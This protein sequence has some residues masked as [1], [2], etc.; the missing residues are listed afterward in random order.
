MKRFVYMTLLVAVLCGAAHGARIKAMILDGQNN[1]DW[2]ATTPVLKELLAETGLFT[3]DVVTS[4]PEG[5]D[6][7]NFNPAFNNYGVVILNYAGDMWN[8]AT[9]KAFIDYVRGGGGV[10]VVHAADNAFGQ[11]KEYNEIIGFG[12]WGGRTKDSGPY[13]YLKDGKLF[14]DYENDGPAGAHEGYAK[15]VIDTQLPEHPIMKGMPAKWYQWDELYNFM[16][17]PGKNMTVLATAYSG[18]PKDQGGSGRH[19]PM[20]VTISYGKGRVFHTA[21]GHDE[22]SIRCKGFDATFTRGA[23]WAA[24]GKVT[25]PLP[26]DIPRPLAPHEALGVLDEDDSYHP[27][28]EILAE[29]SDLSDNPGKL[30][31][32]EAQLIGY[33]EDPDTPFLAI[34]GVCNALG[35]TGSKA[36]VPALAN[37]LTEDAEHASAARLALERIEGPEAVAALLDEL[38]KG[39]DFNQVGIINTLGRRREAG[40]VSELAPLAKSGDTAVARASIDALG[41]IGSPEALAVLQELPESREKTTALIVCAYQL[42][43]D[44][45]KTAQPVLRNLLEESGLAQHNRT[46]A[47]RGMLMLDPDQGM[48]H[49]WTMLEDEAESAVALNVLGSVPGSAQLATDILDHFDGL[50]LE[51]QVALAA[52]LGAMGQPEARPKMLELAQSDF[53]PELKQ[54][55]ITALGGIP[56]DEASV[57]F[58][59]SLAIDQDSDLRQAA[60]EA[61]VNTPGT[62]A[63]D[64]IIDGIRS[65]GKEERTEFM[66][67][68]EARFLER[69]CPALLQVAR[70]GDHD[71]RESAFDVLQK[72]AGPEEY[73]TL[74]KLTVDA[75]Q[76]V[77]RAAV[78]AVQYASRKVADPADRLEPIAGAMEQGS[79]DVKAALMPILYDISSDAALAV[80]ENYA[81]S[82]AEPVQEAAFA[83]LGEWKNPAALQ[84]VLNLAASTRN[85]EHRV[86]LMDAFGALIVNS[87][88]LP[89]DKVLDQSRRALEIGL[90][91]D[92]K[93]ALLRALAQIKDGR[94]LAII[95]EVG[96]EPD[97]AD[98]AKRGALTI[99]QEMIGDPVLS[100]SH[101]ARE[102]PKALDGD[103]GSR[104]ST[105]ASMRPGMWFGIDLRMQSQ[106]HSIILDTTGSNGDY[107][108]GYEV[109]VD[110]KE[111]DTDTAT[112]VLT[113]A[114]DDPV[115]T[116]EFEPPVAGRHIKIVQTGTEGLFWSI[117]E[118][119]VLH[120]PGLDSVPVPAVALEEL[121]SG[122]GFITQW[123][124]AGPFERGG[125]DGDAL[126]DIN[127]G[128]E[129]GAGMAV[130]LPLKPEAIANGIVD[131]EKLYGGDNRVAYLIT[132]I[133]A[134]E[135]TEVTLGVGSD[136]SI[137]VWHDG[138]VI[139]AHK[140]V[141]PVGVDSNKVPLHLKKG[142]NQLMLKV[143]DLTGQWGACARIFTSP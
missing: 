83:A 125:A 106:I 45:S 137:K 15:I 24:T 93:R 117:H 19:E 121:L 40:A 27:A 132:N 55:A 36:A 14:H 108:R 58:L 99:K 111:I 1:H 103:P 20:L 66:I 32:I 38:K 114:G 69:A 6:Q 12:G 79:D 141:R 126:F 26:D 64:V 91:I 54:A 42:I 48:K 57:K 67:A 75:P 102:L 112:P 7:A 70:H 101:N 89:V 86:A 90:D 95:E 5:E 128:P 104:W 28:Q 140:A 109:Y 8:P 61:L 115:T 51:T 131:F 37:L 9:R 34:Q 77:R 138:E 116:I 53:Q 78:R 139:L 136:D 142:D 33:L 72:L 23:E 134:A 129:T 3:V 74:I 30:A 29:L 98:A 84:S 56:G 43:E 21:L 96:Q 25:I 87:D 100:A 31:E 63:E 120:D 76:R 62:K 39:R 94:A 124:V 10:V 119:S 52:I 11:W 122:K 85:S 16:R 127:F 82:G 88:D 133:V 97:L 59:C 4:P 71:L 2:K 47:L 60:H 113:G 35:A 41:K 18:R 110:D 80:V 123:N 22:R 107:P 17:G 65:A 105:G 50:A 92:G 81:K 135:S 44:G 73:K 68:A 130:W 13:V 118:L 143:V 49:V 46:A